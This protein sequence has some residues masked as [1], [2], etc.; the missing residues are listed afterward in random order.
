MLESLLV[1]R[2]TAGTIALLLPLCLLSLILARS[3]IR[4]FSYYREIYQ[5]HFWPD[6]PVCGIRSR[7]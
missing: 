7:C 6:S 4:A 3:V 2:S 5:D 1:L